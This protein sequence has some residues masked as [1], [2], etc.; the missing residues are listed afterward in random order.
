VKGFLYGP[1][2]RTDANDGEVPVKGGRGTGVGMGIQGVG[3][4]VQSKADSRMVKV[5]HLGRHW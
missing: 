1:S 2:R 5:P 3:F 4:S